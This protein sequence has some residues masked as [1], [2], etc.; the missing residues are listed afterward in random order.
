MLLGVAT[1]L[2]SPAIAVVVFADFEAVRFFFGDP[3]D[4]LFFLSLLSTGRSFA[5][6]FGDKIASKIISSGDPKL[7]GTENMK[8]F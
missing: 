3:S 7:H 2:L 5:A 8:L 6:L 1:T 4:A